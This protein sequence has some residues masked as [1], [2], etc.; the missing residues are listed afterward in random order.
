MPQQIIRAQSENSG[1][2]LAKSLQWSAIIDSEF[3]DQSNMRNAVQ[4]PCSKFR[5][6]LVIMREEITLKNNPHV[7]TL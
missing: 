4:Q 2:P 1:N 3:V 5:K 7:L 6:E